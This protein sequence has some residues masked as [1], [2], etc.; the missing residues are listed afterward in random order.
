VTVPTAD[1]K[2]EDW[3]GARQGC[4]VSLIHFNLCSEYCAKKAL[5]GC[6]DFKIGGQVI[7][8]LRYADDLVQFGKKERGL[9]GMTERLIEIGRCYGMEMN[10]GKIR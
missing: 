3:R 10:V 6:G 2:S 1:E 7:C 5:E 8:T 9:Q 4:C